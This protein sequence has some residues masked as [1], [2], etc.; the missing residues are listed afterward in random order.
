MSKVKLPREKKRL[1]LALDRRNSYRENS[2]ASRKGI[3]LSK[4]RSHRGERHAISIA[5]NSLNT[6][7]EEAADAVEAEARA[8]GKQR[9]VGAFRKLPT[10]RLVFTSLNSRF[11]ALVAV[12]VPN[13]SPKRIAGVGTAVRS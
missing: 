10:S 9:K 11:A 8:S 12:H 3:P 2:K 13:Y 1:S 4:A 7:S 6:A 5:M